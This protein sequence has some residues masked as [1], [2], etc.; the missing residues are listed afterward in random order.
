MSLLFFPLSECLVARVDLA[1]IIYRMNGRPNISTGLKIRANFVRVRFAC[2]PRASIAARPLLFPDIK[3]RD[4]ST[5]FL[6]HVVSAPVPLAR[7]GFPRERFHRG[8]SKRII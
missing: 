5:F 6:R 3:H 8:T 2:G 7:D 4:T 1:K